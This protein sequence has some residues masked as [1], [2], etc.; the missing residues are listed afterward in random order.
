ME[1]IGHGMYYEKVFRKL[2]ENGVRFVVVGGVALVLHGVVRLTVDLDL[3][4]EMS[5]DNLTRFITAMQDM[6]YRPKPPVKAEEFIDPAKR[7]SWKEEKGMR[8]FS[9]FHPKEPGRLIDVFVDEPIKFTEV[10][11]NKKIVKTENLQIPIVSLDHLKK[12]KLIAGRPQDLADIEALETLEE[13][14]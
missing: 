1:S 7:K 9:F 12:L 2:H 13:M 3:M 6:G 14:E 11:R 4:V 5:R 10:E 8:V